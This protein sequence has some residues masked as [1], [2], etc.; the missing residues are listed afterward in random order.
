MSSTGRGDRQ[1]EPRRVPFASRGVA[2]AR[3]LL[4]GFGLVHGGHVEHALLDLG[5]TG[6]LAELAILVG[7]LA[8]KISAISHRLAPT[9]RAHPR[10]ARV[11]PTLTTHLRCGPSRAPPRLASR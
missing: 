6:D 7:H 1:R 11:S 8:K 3:R 4:V 9:T 10:G 2:T 5:I